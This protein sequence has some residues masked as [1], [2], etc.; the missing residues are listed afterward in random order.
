MSGKGHVMLAHS[1][2]GV[3]DMSG[4]WI[5]EKLDG[6]RAYWDG[7][8]LITR[9]GNEIA[10]PD[11]ILVELPIGIALDGELFM[12]RKRFQ[13]L[14]RGVKGDLGWEGIRY[15]VFDAPSELQ[16]E[17]RMERLGSLLHVRQKVRP[18]EHHLCID[19]QHLLDS[20]DSIIANGG[21]GLMLREP[22]SLYEPGRS[23]SMLKAKRFL[24]DEAV[25]ISYTE[26]KGKHKGRIGAIIVRNRHGIN[27]S[28]GTGLTDKDRESPPA[29]GSIISYKYQE[30]TTYGVPRFPVYIGMCIDKAITYEW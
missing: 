15:M 26:G 5:S 23:R 21:E 19:N 25:V 27:F 13:D 28:L 11:S 12:G 7:T 22:G 6:I 10:A 9:L 2:N 3:Q 14:V 8:R 24:D 4:W 17:E 29:V 16:F 30:L 1:W 20:L 18:V